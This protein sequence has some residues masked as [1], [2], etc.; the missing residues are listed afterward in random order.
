MDDAAFRAALKNSETDAARFSGRIGQMIQVQTAGFRRLTGA[1]NSVFLPFTSIIGTI[2]LVTGLVATVGSFFDITGSNARAAAEEQERYND[3]IRQSQRELANLGQKARVELGE[4]SSFEAQLRDAAQQN[5]DRLNKAMKDFDSAD[6]ARRRS[7]IQEVLA[8]D[9]ATRL[10]DKPSISGGAPLISP[11]TRSSLENELDTI[12]QKLQ[13]YAE[14]VDESNER[15]TEQIELIRRAR[16]ETIGRLQIQKEI[17]LATIEGNTLTAEL[18]QASERYRASLKDVEKLRLDDAAAAERLLSVVKRI[19]DAERKRAYD[20]QREREARAAQEAADLARRKSE[21]AEIARQEEIRR[22]IEEQ[23]NAIQE[24][25]RQEREK[26]R[27]RRLRIENDEFAIRQRIEELRLKGQ[28][29][30]ADRLERELELR[31]RIRDIQDREGLG[32]DERRRLIE[33]ETELAKLREKAAQSEIDAE[34][35]RVAGFRSLGPS[36]ISGTT[37][38]AMQTFGTSLL[39]SVNSKLVT[40]NTTLNTSVNR[41]RQA[42]ETAS[43]NG[44]RFA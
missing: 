17:Q 42:I 3:A 4:L 9:D 27:Q 8:L 19:Y 13:E 6:M 1:I 14:F 29:E 23:E 25:A 40:A 30:E 10:T 41:L 24:T 2:T 33:K 20:A 22:S 32:E 38:I 15:Y 37:Q 18:M 26:E 28:K 44:A 34:R 12:N 36:G 21:E 39:A 11:L 7:R 31:Q 5:I 43:N 35:V 16:E